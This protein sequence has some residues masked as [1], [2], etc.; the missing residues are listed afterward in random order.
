MKGM[1][2]QMTEFGDCLSELTDVGPLGG[3]VL[4]NEVKKGNLRAKKYG[5]KVIVLP[6]DYRVFLE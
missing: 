6:Y 3:A 1:Q 5:S 2:P 4:T